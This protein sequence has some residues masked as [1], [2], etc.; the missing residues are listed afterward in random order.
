KDYPGFRDKYRASTLLK[1]VWLAAHTTSAFYSLRF[2]RAGEKFCFVKIDMKGQ[3]PDT[4]LDLR[5]RLEHQLSAALREE[6]LGEVWGGGTGLRYL[7]IDLAV[8]DVPRGAEV[9]HRAA[10]T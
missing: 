4:W 2:S 7:Y 10:L 8:L 1:D 9:A 6:D 3:D 5:T